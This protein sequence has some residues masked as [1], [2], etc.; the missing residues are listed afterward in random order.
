MSSHLPKCRWISEDLGII[1]RDDCKD[2]L[3]IAYITL[4]GDI[5]YSLWTPCDGKDFWTKR[6]INGVLHGQCGTQWPHDERN[7]QIVD[8]KMR[9]LFADMY[10]VL[11]IV[12][13]EHEPYCITECV[14][15]ELSVYVN[16]LTDI[17]CIVDTYN[18]VRAAERIVC[19][20]KTMA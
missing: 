8:E 19:H 2:I 17:E 12:P 20:E 9:W 15:E 18:T 16:V 10:D 1:R 13:V 3:C 6:E 4:A 11:N 14:G 5:L 7:V